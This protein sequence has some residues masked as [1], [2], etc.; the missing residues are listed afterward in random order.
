MHR[1][2]GAVIYGMFLTTPLRMA[3][4]VPGTSLL[5]PGSNA[6]Y[7]NNLLARY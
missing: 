2:K 7:S 5:A 3:S 1:L 4:K 6:S